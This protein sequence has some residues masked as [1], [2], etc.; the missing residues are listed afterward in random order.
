MEQVW[1]EKHGALTVVHFGEEYRSSH[2]DLLQ[3][4]RKRLEQL[5]DDID[6]PVLMLDLLNTDYF[7][8]GF[9]SVLVDCYARIKRRDGQFALC[10]LRHHLVEEFEVTNLH[11]LWP[12]YATRNQGIEALK[13]EN[14]MVG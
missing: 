14:K 11:R 6:P 12:I 3:Q 7:G 4:L 5:A 10:R 8:A 1:I 13:A 2:F 9:I